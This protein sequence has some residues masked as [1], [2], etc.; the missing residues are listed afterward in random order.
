MLYIKGQ[1]LFESANE[2]YN[3]V[4]FMKEHE[5]SFK[6][7]MLSNQNAIECY[8]CSMIEILSNKTID[9]FYGRGRV[10]HDLGR[11]YDD[12]YSLDKNHVLPNYNRKLKRELQGAFYDFKSTRYPKENNFRIVDIESL[13]FDIDITCEIKEISKEF[14]EYVNQMTNQT[15]ESFLL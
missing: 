8:L 5:L 11:L 15:K 13:D 10:P 7:I 1:T 12:L 6:S 9:D 2:T 14:Y 4:L 3:D